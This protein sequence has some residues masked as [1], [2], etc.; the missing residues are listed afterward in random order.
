MVKLTGMV[1]SSRMYSEFI[2]PNSRVIRLYKRIIIDLGQKL[3]PTSPFQF[4]LPIMTALYCDICGESAPQKIKDFV[5]G[6]LVDK[7][8]IQYRA[9]DPE[10]EYAKQS[11]LRALAY[12]SWE[13]ASRLFLARRVYPTY[14]DFLSYSHCH[15]GWGA[16]G[17]M[18]EQLESE[19]KEYI[20]SK[21]YTVVK[22][23]GQRALPFL[24][25]VERLKFKAILAVPV[26]AHSE[27]TAHDYSFKSRDL[28]GAYL[29]FLQDDSNLPER[30]LK[31]KKIADF[32]TALGNFT[33][34]TQEALEAQSNML[35]TISDDE[36]TELAKTWRD[37]ADVYSKR[38]YIFEVRLQPKKTIQR[39][40]MDE[41]SSG[42]I[43]ALSGAEF[44]AI[45]EQGGDYNSSEATVLV[46]GRKG[47]NIKSEIL[48]AV[49]TACKN[50]DPLD[51][52][53]H[54]R[55]LGANQ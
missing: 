46:A 12:F 19:P 36:H 43:A 16:L 28:H 29:L 13:E 31:S 30:V 2:A 53:I 22:E 54:I 52:H 8:K 7:S 40:E 45:V 33:D 27:Q 4:T 10:L 1:M 23:F 14:F 47:G 25:E 5:D 51:I 49:G 18:L 35:K 48:R 50:L 11:P 24:V 21:V 9:Q 3:K 6:L 37:S 32:R 20:S 26:V 38:I 44:H 42:V 41:I 17:T 39:S 55:K 15:E 34:K